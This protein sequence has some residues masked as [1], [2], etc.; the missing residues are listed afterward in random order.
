MT[1]PQFKVPRE[2]YLSREFLKWRKAQPWQ[3][4]SGKT[5]Y[6]FL[7]ARHALY[8]GLKALGV[9]SGDE[10]LVPAYICGAAV[11]AVRACGALPVYFRVDLN[12][13]LNV[14]DAESRI[15]SRTRALMVVQ[16]FGFTQELRYFRELAK[17]KDLVIVEDCAHILPQK[18]PD[19]TGDIRVFS[20]RKFVSSLYGA[21]LEIAANRLPRV[22]LRRNP[23]AGFEVKVLKSLLEATPA[24]SSVISRLGGVISLTRRKTKSRSFA[25]KAPSVT[26]EANNSSFDVALAA[27]SL[28]RVSRWIGSHSD[29]ERIVASRRRNYMELAQRIAAIPGVAS[30]FPE[31]EPENCPLYFPVVMKGIDDA[32]KQIREL[33][34]P[35][36]AW[37]G[38][39]PEGISS[40]SFPEAAFL[41][42]NL[43]FLPIHQMLG[44]RELDQ[45]ADAVRSVRAR[46]SRMMPACSTIDNSTFGREAV[47]QAKS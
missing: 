36:T 25:E 28:S 26:F 30:L 19:T 24:A 21:E 43:T 7:L 5:R 8:H 22:K 10:V 15:T 16:Y 32:H 4:T 20:W 2:Q 13:A 14:E 44:D 37:D 38:V 27:S 40:A 9:S 1:S 42:G 31:L 3:P 39:R 17:R 47:C 12:C 6:P 34:I 33:G 29:L 41:Y 23:S 18:Y 46:N 45:I 11:E 35:A